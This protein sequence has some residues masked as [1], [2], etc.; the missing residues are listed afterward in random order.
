MKIKAGLTVLL[1]LVGNFLATAQINFTSKTEEN[2]FEPIG[3]TLKVG[4]N[5]SNVILQP[6]PLNI[7]SNKNAFHIG[8][9][10][11]DLK[12]AKN[13]VLQ[14]EILYSLQGFSVASVGKIGLHYLSAP[15]LLKAP[16]SKNLD[17]LAGPQISYLANARIGLG[18]DLFSLRYKGAFQTWDFSAVAGAEYA[19]NKKMA[20]GGRYVHGLNN[21][22]KDFN[23]GGANTLN[24]YV[25]F[26]NSNVQLYMR[27][28]L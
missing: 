9:V 18:N 15:L 24:D 21:I 1:L 11:R 13:I 27:V 16:I 26:K 14:P 6:E 25:S 19:L 5:Y 23:W 4:Y 8:V 20:V 17:V 22:N 28:A 12:V 2:N 10:T 7:I 3:L